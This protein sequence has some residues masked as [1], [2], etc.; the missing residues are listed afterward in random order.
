M[1]TPYSHP[2][3]SFTQ[4]TTCLFTGATIGAGVYST[5]GGVG[6]VGGFGGIGL[7][8]TP[9][10]GV[11]AVAGA[12][13]YGVFRAINDQDPVVWGAIGLGTI[14][15]MAVSAGVGGIGVGFAGTAVGVGM[16][17]L[18]VFGGVVGLGLYGIGKLIDGAGE[19]SFQAYARIS[20]LLDDGIYHQE[21]YLQALL[22]LTAEY[23]ENCLKQKISELEINDDLAELKAKLQQKPLKQTNNQPLEGTCDTPENPLKKDLREL[24]SDDELAKLKAKIQGNS[25]KATNEKP[26]IKEKEDLN[27]STVNSVKIID[28]E[29]SRSRWYCVKTLKAHTAVINT[30]AFSP[31]SQTLVTGSDDKTIHIFDVNTGKQKYTFYTPHEVYSIVISSNLNIRSQY[32]LFASGDRNGR[33]TIWNW[34]TRQLHRTLLDHHIPEQNIGIVHSLVFNQ[35]GNFLV[36]GSSD[37]TVRI[38]NPITGSCKRILNGHEQAVLAVILSPDQQNVISAS[39]DKT[40]RIWKINEYEK[41]QVLT[42]H[43]DWVTCLALT[44]DGKILV[45]GSTDKT[46]KFWKLETGELIKTLTEHSAAI[47]SVM[48]HPDGEILASGSIDGRVNLLNLQTGELLQTLRGYSPVVFSPDG[49]RLV[50]GDETGVL[51]IWQQSYI[52]NEFNFDDVLTEWWEVLGVDQQATAKEVKEVYYQ[53]ARIYHPDYNSNSR[54]IA[55]M[56]QIN[57]AYEQF[58]GKW[59]QTVWGRR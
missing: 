5:I 16:G 58:L 9:L 35:N 57:R 8:M 15:G 14:G 24:E 23:Q 32:S 34:Y 3:K 46:I 56:Q 27:A 41:P 10:M 18:G 49:K 17:T 42:G 30:I 40:I 21:F 1:A 47:F 53:L 55:K 33:I 19:S 22:E 13:T 51:K 59:S 45:S 31:D 12:A 39:A 2:S 29:N 6:M 11:G 37:K 36:S 38:W 25:S 7:G 54:A 48:V 26:P 43:S 28:I 44:P 4:G 20:E 52:E 50:T